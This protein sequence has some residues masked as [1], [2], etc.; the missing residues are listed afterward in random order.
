MANRR[1]EQTQSV[2]MQPVLSQAAAMQQA[3]LLQLPDADFQKL[4]SEIE[5]DSLFRYLY[6]EEKIIRYR[7][8]PGTDI[9][10]VYYHENDRAAS[11]GL[12]P[13]IEEFMEN[14]ADIFNAVRKIGEDNFK[15]YFLFPQDN[16]TVE[17]TA[18]ACNISS[19]EAEEIL[20]LVNDLAVISSFYHPPDSGLVMLAYTCIASIEACENDFMI[21]YLSPAYARGCYRIDYDK[22]ENLLHSGKF[23]RQLMSKG[24]HLLKNLELINNRKTVINRILFSLANRQSLFLKSG[25]QAALL[26]LSQKEIA[27]ET[28]VAPSSVSRAI[29][30]K[31]IMTPSRAEIPLKQLLPNPRI[32]KKELIRQVVNNEPGLNSDEAIREKLREKFGVV[33]SRRSV[34]DLRNELHIPSRGKKQ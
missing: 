33:V 7:K 27:A 8:F 11:G 34:A 30:R 18:Y 5:Q 26:P 17:E 25:D 10:P 14:H 32:F 22:F 28:G 1:A 12:S 6:R 29:H 13:G 9:Y 16:Y 2:K 15:H 20:S 21:R 19:T 3:D 24:R 23:D 31:S 4:I